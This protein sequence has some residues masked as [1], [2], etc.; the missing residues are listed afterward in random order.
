MVGAATETTVE[1]SSS[2]TDIAST[3]PKPRTRLAVR[4]AAAWAAGS[5]VSVVIAISLERN[6]L[7]CY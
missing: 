2:I 5:M 7:F 6:E 1:S 3:A 4:G